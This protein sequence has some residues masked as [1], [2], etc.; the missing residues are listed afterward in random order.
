MSASPIPWPRLPTLEE[1][2]E[3]VGVSPE[4]LDQKCADES[5]K[6]LAKYCGP[7]ER[8]ARQLFPA[9]TIENLIEEIEKDNRKADDQRS[10]FVRRWMRELGHEAKYSIFMKALLQF[11][12]SKKVEN[13]LKRLKKGNLL[14]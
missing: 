2:C 11:Q 1:I 7:W 9:D 4:A 10:E 14:G 13:I 3:Q 8:V 5:Q 12:L 6:I